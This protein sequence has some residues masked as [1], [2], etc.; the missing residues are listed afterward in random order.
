MR[1]FQ[2]APSARKGWKLVE[3]DMGKIVSASL[4]ARAWHVY[5]LL[6]G[7]DRRVR[8][9]ADA[10]NRSLDTY[11]EFV[12]LAGFACTQDTLGMRWSAEG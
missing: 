2:D 11:R 12:F 3:K 10:L 8:A 9:A 6:L 5:G 1:I 7:K 4:Y